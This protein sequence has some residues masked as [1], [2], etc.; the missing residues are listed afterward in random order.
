MPT[1]EPTDIGDVFLIK[2]EIHRDERGFFLE[3]FRE[4]W[5]RERGIEVQFVQ[6]NLSRSQ[7]GTVRGLHYQIRRRQAK[8][9]MVVSGTIRDVA[10]DLRR[11]SPTF[12]QHTSV[13]LSEVN[14]RQLYI[15]QGFAHGFSVLSE[16]ALVAYKCSDYYDAEAERGVLWNDPG[17]GIE[18]EVDRPVVSDKDRQQPR[19]T[20]IPKKDLF[21]YQP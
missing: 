19:L 5:F 17:L 9:I 3:T 16:E 15:P 11:G 21:E 18:W 2:P 8:L 4:E 13:V 20:E 10:L 7:R 6:D 1:F 12:G 14:K